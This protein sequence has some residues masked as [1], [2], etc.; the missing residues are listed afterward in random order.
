MDVMGINHCQNV[1]VS[2]YC[3]T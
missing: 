2:V 1:S 3:I